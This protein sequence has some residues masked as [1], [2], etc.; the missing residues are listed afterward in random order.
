MK[1]SFVFLCIACF[2]LGIAISIAFHHNPDY[3]QVPEN[4]QRI[5]RAYKEAYL[6]GAE[7]GIINNRDPK[8]FWLTFKIDVIVEG[9]LDCSNNLTEE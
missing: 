2:C 5:M 3:R 4:V 6:K 7:N 1:T 9:L 8:I